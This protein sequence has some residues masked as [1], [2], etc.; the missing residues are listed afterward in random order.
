[1]REVGRVC[2]KRRQFETLWHDVSN[3]GQSKVIGSRDGGFE[4][5]R[6][7]GYDTV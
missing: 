4:N 3:R 2:P 5:D 6:L 1:M 7:L